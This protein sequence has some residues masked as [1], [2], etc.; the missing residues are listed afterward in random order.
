MTSVTADKKDYKRVVVRPKISITDEDPV[1]K[2]LGNHKM[3]KFAGC[4]DVYYPVMDRQ[5]G[6]YLTGL[7]ENHPSVLFLPQDEKEKKQAEIVAERTYLE[8]E[9]GVS[10]HHSNDA[11]WGALE[12]IIDRGISFNLDNP[13]DKVKYN[14]LVAADLLP[15]SLEDINNPKYNGSNFYLGKDWEDVSQ[16]NSLRH[17][18]R[19]VAAEL[20]KLLE[21]VPYAIEIAKYIGV[22]DINGNIPK[23]NLDDMLSEFIERNAAKNKEI[24]LEAMKTP[25]EEVIL[26]NQFQIFKRL[27]LVNFEEGVWKSG[28]VK[29]GKTDKQA[30]KKLLSTS[31]D[32]QS[33][34]SN[35]MEAFKESVSKKKGV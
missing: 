17:R 22:R 11:Y 33:E 20:E 24:F 5:L 6:R 7:D 16:K 14:C 1:G 34:L 29:I 2:A 26:L 32:M 25:R 30:V 31:P 23:E 8:K 10:L 12:I 3:S 13:Y 18:D 35:L 27:K 4:P 21:D 9:L 15:T 28:N 19:K